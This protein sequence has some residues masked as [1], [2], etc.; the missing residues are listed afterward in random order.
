MCIYNYYMYRYVKSIALAPKNL[1]K[2]KTF[3]STAP[4][5]NNIFKKV[6]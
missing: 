2:D 1:V 4:S 3:T 6:I 5:S